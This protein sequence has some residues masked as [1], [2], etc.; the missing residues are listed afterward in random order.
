M[1]ICIS[2]KGQGD[3]HNIS[4]P[5]FLYRNYIPTTTL[6]LNEETQRW[7]FDCKISRSHLRIRNAEKIA[8]ILNHL[9]VIVH[10]SPFPKIKSTSREIQFSWKIKNPYYSKGRKKIQTHQSPN[11]SPQLFQTSRNYLKGRNNNK[12]LKHTRPETGK[13]PTRV[14]ELS[15]LRILEGTLKQSIG[16]HSKSVFECEVSGEGSQPLP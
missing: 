7:S 12:S 11:W 3:A 8:L 4:W 16:S 10:P 2:N 9:Q 6:S 13:K 5:N 14:A 15:G 1:I